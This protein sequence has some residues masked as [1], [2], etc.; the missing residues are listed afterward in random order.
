MGAKEADAW[1]AYEW[2]NA[3]CLA[4]M[5]LP[6]RHSNEV[7]LHRARGEGGPRHRLRG[8]NHLHTL[9]KVTTLSDSAKLQFTSL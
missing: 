8:W 5:D 4:L 2:I 7:V 1:C 9:N 6:Q 3:D